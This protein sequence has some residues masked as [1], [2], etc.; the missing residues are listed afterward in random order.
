MEE[1]N[2]QMLEPHYII[3]RQINTIN[4]AWLSTFDVS[5]MTYLHVMLEY[6]LYMYIYIFDTGQREKYTIRIYI[7]LVVEQWEQ[8]VVLEAK[9]LS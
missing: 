1:I 9:W 5:S 6:I 8:I 7:E 4:S 2:N 3:S